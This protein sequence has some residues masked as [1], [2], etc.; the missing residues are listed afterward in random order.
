MHSVDYIGTPHITLVFAFSG[1]N[2]TIHYY[3]V[4]LYLEILEQNIEKAL[5]TVYQKEMGL[6]N[7]DLASS[8]VQ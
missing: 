6:V 5:I 3:N 7:V 8:L 2:E 4:L 1:K